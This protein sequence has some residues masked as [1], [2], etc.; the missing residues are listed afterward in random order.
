MPLILFAL[1][2]DPGSFS[3]TAVGKK[4]SFGDTSSL[5]VLSYRQQ[6]ARRKR[7]K[8]SNRVLLSRGERRQG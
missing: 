2:T 1:D 5:P 6:W 3:P 8:S 7:E 4:G